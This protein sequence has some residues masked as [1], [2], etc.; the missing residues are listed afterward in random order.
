[1]KSTGISVKNLDE[2]DLKLSIAKL[3]PEKPMLDS[4]NLAKNVYHWRLDVLI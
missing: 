3:L 4:H 1:M 2:Q